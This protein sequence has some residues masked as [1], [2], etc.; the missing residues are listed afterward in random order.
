MKTTVTGASD[1]LVQHVEAADESLRKSFSG[2]DVSE[3]VP[4]VERSVAEL[5]IALSADD[6]RAWAQKISDRADHQLT[7]R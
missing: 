1:D 2:M 7:L 4:E 5:D 3:I 6:I